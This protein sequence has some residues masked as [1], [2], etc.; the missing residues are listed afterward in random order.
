MV[1]SVG[2]SIIGRKRSHILHACYFKIRMGDPL[3]TPAFGKLIKI[4]KYQRE[5]NNPNPI[6]ILNWKNQGSFRKI[7]SQ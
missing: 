4:T 7:V 2:G 1:G 5:C 3:L 6:K